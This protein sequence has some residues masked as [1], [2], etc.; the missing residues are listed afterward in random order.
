LAASVIWR[1]P[2]YSNFRQVLF[3]VPPIFLI[4]ALGIDLVWSRLR[5]PWLKALLVIVLLL[6]GLAAIARLRPYEY[7]YYNSLV[8][9]E[10][11]AVGEFP[12][13]YWC[14]SYREAMVYV[15]AHAPAGARV[16]VSEPFGAAATFARPDLRVA[17]RTDDSQAAYVLRCN[18]RG[19]LTLR[20]LEEFPVAFAVVRSGVVLSVVLR[21]ET[22]PAGSSRELGPALFVG[23]PVDGGGGT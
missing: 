2:L 5:A 6:P 10:G 15:N 14:A 18:N 23:R 3:A 7:I 1:V 22:A 16:A 19:D 17:P 11:G 4:A 20:N 12:H 21:P 9:G 13:D 8:G